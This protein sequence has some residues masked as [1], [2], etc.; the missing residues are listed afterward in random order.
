MIRFSILSMTHSGHQDIMGL[1]GAGTQE[2]TYPLDGAVSEDHITIHG[3]GA[4]IHIIMTASTRHGTMTGTTPLIIMD[5]T[6]ISGE[7]ITTIIIIHKPLP[8]AGTGLFIIL[9]QGITRQEMLPGVVIRLGVPPL[10]LPM[11]MPPGG[12]LLLEPSRAV[13]G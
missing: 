4:T 9:K 13:A 11:A 5:I 1:P 2:Y 10:Q 6:A 8:L 12:Q 3:R 7:V